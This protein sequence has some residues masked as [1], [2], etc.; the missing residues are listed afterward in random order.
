MI[1]FDFPGRPPVGPCERSCDIRINIINVYKQ[2][3]FTNDYFV[4]I[5]LGMSVVSLS[6]IGLPR[7][8]MFCTYLDLLVIAF[9]SR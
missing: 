2:S 5:K 1:N 9:S 4:N 6:K 8:A 3:G 7:N